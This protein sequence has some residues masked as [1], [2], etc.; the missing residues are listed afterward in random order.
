MFA[1]T[2]STILNRTFF[3]PHLFIGILETTH[4]YISEICFTL[5]P[6]NVRSL[7]DE[8]LRK[9]ILYHNETTEFFRSAKFQSIHFI[10]RTS[11]SLE[12]GSRLEES[13][14]GIDCIADNFEIRFSY[15][16]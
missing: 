4:S 11:Q 5:K 13:E 3:V 8:A 16:S 7:L 9:T 6:F 2:S 15:H 1:L 14:T 10:V 12:R